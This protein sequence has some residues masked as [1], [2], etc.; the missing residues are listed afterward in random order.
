MRIKTIEEL[1]K[2]D[3]VKFEQFIDR[4]IDAVIADEG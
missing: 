2:E 1:E 3:P 4:V